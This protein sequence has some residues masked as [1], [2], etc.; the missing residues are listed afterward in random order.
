MPSLPVNPRKLIAGSLGLAAKGLQIGAFAARA[1]AEKLGQQ[2]EDDGAAP[3]REASQEPQ[4][5]VGGNGSPGAGAGVGRPRRQPAPVA[6]IRLD[7]PPAEE[8]ERG[9]VLQAPTEPVPMVDQHVRTF[10]THAAELAAKSA[11]D[12]IDA[13]ATLSTDD[14]RLLYEHEQA[15]KKRKTVLKAIEAQL[16]PVG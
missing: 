2:A 12:V 7:A 15:N 9:T 6:E 8:M 11:G 4:G 5:R 13:I 10:E 3:A 1:V 14:L 16:T